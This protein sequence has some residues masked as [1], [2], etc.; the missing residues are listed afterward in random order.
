M[1]KFWIVLLSLGLI[2]A[3]CMP[4]AALDV[5]MKGSY[6]VTGIYDDNRQIVGDSSSMAFYAQ[7]IRLEPVFKI[8]EGLTF[9]MRADAMERVWGQTPVGSEDLQGGWLNSRNKANEQNIE[10]RRGW[11]DFVTRIGAFRVGYMG[12]DAWGTDFADRS[13]EAAQIVYSIKVGPVVGVAALAKYGEGRLGGTDYIFNN[14]IAAGNT[15]SDTDKY[16]LSLLYFAQQ[17]QGGFLWC[18]V[19]DAGPRNA[20]HYSLWYD[21]FQ[22]YYKLA[23]GG[24]SSEAEIDYYNGKFM[25]YDDGIHATDVDYEGWQWWIMA[26]YTIGPAYIGAQYA[27]SS[28]DG[29]GLA[30]DKNEQVGSGNVWQPTLILWNDWI[31]RFAGNVGYTAQ[32]DYQFKNADLYQIFAGYNPVPKL[33]IKASVT[34]A[35]ADEVPSNYEDDDYGY[36]FDLTASYKLFDN[37]EYMVG[38]GYL[39][40]GDYFKGSNSHAEVDN[41]YLILNQLTLTF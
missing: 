14:S 2:A 10:L 1:K 27:H 28:G 25:D 18:R 5:Q 6:I 26:R 36:E 29:N 31:Q 22:A 32:V 35:N 23:I 15:D 39:W 41:D 8:A 3:F 12:S 21:T 19:D 11:V 24:L 20:A 34:Y 33:A 38:F 37:L 9:S 13:G 17:G 7:R 4:A 16:C 40:A 30:D